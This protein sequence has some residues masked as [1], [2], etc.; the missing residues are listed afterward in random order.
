MP[1]VLDVDI[2]PICRCGFHQSLAISSHHFGLMNDEKRNQ[3]FSKLFRNCII[4]KQTVCL[5]LGDS[6]I[7]L[8]VTALAFGAKAVYI[9]QSPNSGDDLTLFNINELLQ[10]NNLSTNVHV[11]RKEPSELTCTD[12]EGAKVNFFLF[13]IPTNEWLNRFN[14]NFSWTWFSVSPV[15]K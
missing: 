15:T 9:L 4:P 11:L 10:K 8:P 6:D 1:E 13:T 12:F 7:I 2:P 5:C 3:K 14:F